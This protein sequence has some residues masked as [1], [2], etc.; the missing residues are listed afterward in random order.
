MVTSNMTKNFNLIAVIYLD[1]DP[2]VFI[3]WH[4]KN[5][6]ILIAIYLL[7][8]DI[9]ICYNTNVICNNYNTELQFIWL[10]GNMV[11]QSEI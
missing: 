9:I 5:N 3:D 7:K 11:I 8:S 4:Y 1:V 6:S 10:M 2:C